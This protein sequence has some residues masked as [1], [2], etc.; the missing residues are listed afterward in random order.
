[1]RL[2][3]TGRISVRRGPRENARR[4][5]IDPLFR[6]AAHFYGPRTVGV[7]LTGAMDDGSAGLL[8][9][10]RAG[11]IAVVQDPN[12]AAVAGMPS[13]TLAVV[14]ADLIP[15]LTSSLQGSWMW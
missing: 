10:K 4:P 11:G 7:V 8:A 9:I 1:M 15:R 5:A 13:N 6:T 12:D 3:D 2:C 14:E